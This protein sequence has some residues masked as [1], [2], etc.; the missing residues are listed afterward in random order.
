MATFGGTYSTGT[1]SVTADDTTV[2]GVGTLWASIAEQGDWL[3]AD[4]NIGIIETVT[5]DTH[6]EL[7]LGWA[8]TTLSGEN[9]RLIKMSWLRYE[10]ALTQKKVRE[11]L[12]KLAT[13]G[14]IYYVTGS[15]PD[16]LI[17]D[18]GNLAVK[19]SVTPW[20]WWIRI[21]GVWEAT[22]SPFPVA[23]Q[24]AYAGGTTYAEGD[25]VTDDGSVWL[26]LQDSNTGNQPDISPSYWEL[27]IS[28]GD[29][30][31]TGP[32]GGD[33]GLKFTF[34][35]ATSGDPGSGKF[36]FDNATFG[37][38]A[39]LHISETDGDSND[40]A[41]LLATL[42][43]STSANKCLVLF[44]KENGSAG[45]LAY[46]TGALS[47]QGDYDTFAITPIS[48]LGTILNNDVCRLIPLRTGDKGEAGTNG[49]DG[50]DGADGIDGASALTVVRVA[51]TGN[52]DISTE[53]EAGDTIDGTT[54]A[55]NDLVLLPAQT[56]PAQNGV[57]VV[58]ASGAASRAAAFDSYDEH[59]GRYFSVQ[60]GTA[61]AGKLY[62]CPS[63]PGGTLDTTAIT[64]EE[65]EGGGGTALTPPQGRLTLTSGVP[66]LTAD[67]TSQTTV[68]YT[69]FVGDRCP[70]YD[71]TGWTVEAFSE[72][73]IAMASSANW[74]SGSV[75]DLFL[76]DDAGTLRLCTGPAWSSSTSRGAGGGTTELTRLNGIYVNAV[77]MTARYGPSSTFSVDANR[78]TYVGSMYMTGNGATGMSFS[79]S[80]VSGGTNNFLAL[81]N[82]YN[83]RLAA[84]I[85]RDS[86]NTWTYASATY[87]AANGSNSNRVTVLIGIQDSV[88]MAVYG[89]RGTASASGSALMA[90]GVDSTTA[91]LGTTGV[92]PTSVSLLTVV[93]FYDGFPGLGLHYFQALEASAAGT[94]TFYGDAGGTLYQM[95]I[96]VKAFM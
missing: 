23:V 24:G 47:D 88:V 85:S 7:E 3:Y 2:T 66:V 52:V 67:A 61:N 6:L 15:E 82:A 94:A 70:I 10:P 77:S 28:K 45:F 63:A 37:S 34:N 22:A 90:V 92:V 75:F 43:D 19:T 44:R 74:P 32:Q 17:G 68:F 40:V 62:H 39:T 57:R 42:D 89:G 5:D 78:A 12:E 83:Q 53:L 49:S 71:G 56:A 59:C 76:A 69:P 84:A 95:G 46:I 54:L 13:I 18:D 96:T 4:G 86:D 31:A 14:I 8:G 11:F 79:P 41:A 35:S 72:L 80:A 87:Q 81:F 93:A 91:S 26:S 55:E 27:F 21:G 65:F 50:A 73:S 64:I 1:I 16:P 20:L 29:T 58:P 60:E 30:G 48:A 9:Y 33:A 36:L 25:L 51:A 38:A